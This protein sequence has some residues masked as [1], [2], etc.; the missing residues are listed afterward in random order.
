MIS[1]LTYGIF[2]VETNSIYIGDIS[3]Y[4]TVK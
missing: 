1:S 3:Y 2:K 4:E